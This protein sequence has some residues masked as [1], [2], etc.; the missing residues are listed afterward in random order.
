MKKLLLVVALLGIGYVVYRQVTA[1]KAEQ[2]LWSEATTEPDL[3]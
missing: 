2:D 1:S 3:R